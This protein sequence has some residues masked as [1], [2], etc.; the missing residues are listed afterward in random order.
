M[1]FA[2]IEIY[3]R[4]N[5]WGNTLSLLTLVFRFDMIFHRRFGG[6]FCR[7]NEHL[8]HHANEEAAD[9]HTPI[10]KR[11]M[12]TALDMLCT[13]YCPC[14]LMYR[15]DEL[16]FVFKKLQVDDFDVQR[17]VAYEILQIASHQC[18]EWC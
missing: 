14:V 16:F 2:C 10:F 9:F 4:G 18:T 17:V 5:D 13:G 6:R 3:I 7:G 11:E 12:G 15:L 1:C 8:W